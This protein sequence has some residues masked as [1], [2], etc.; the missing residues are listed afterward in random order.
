MAKRDT[1]F[2]KNRYRAAY[3]ANFGAATNS[4]SIVKLGSVAVA[5]NTFTAG[6]ILTVAASVNKFGSNGLWNLYLYW[7]ET[8][9]LTTPITIG[10]FTGIT[11]ALL[12]CVVTRRISVTAS[13]GTGS[14]SIVFPPGVNAVSDYTTGSTTAPS[15]LV[16]NWTSS[17]YIIIAGDVDNASD[18]IQARWIKANN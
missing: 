17:S 10:S 2:F 3:S 15:G 12:Q 18:F 14:G 1:Y 16:L 6:D 7:N 9:D 13:D 11:S 5:A 8:D 4:L